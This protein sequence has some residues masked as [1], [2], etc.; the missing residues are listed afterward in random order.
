M[1]YLDDFFMS[2]R[3]K[4]GFNTSKPYSDMLIQVFS[5]YKPVVKENLFRMNQILIEYLFALEKSSLE[6][7]NFDLHIYYSIEISKIKD[8]PLLIKGEL[9]T[10]HILSRDF[11]YIFLTSKII[12]QLFMDLSEKL[13]LSDNPN[14]LKQ[15]IR[16]ER[17]YF[18]SIYNLLSNLIQKKSLDT[19][20][21]SV[22]ESAFEN[23]LSG[24][25]DIHGKIFLWEGITTLLKKINER[26]IE[27]NG[28]IGKVTTYMSSNKS[29]LKRGNTK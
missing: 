11:Q 24:F 8:L 25:E 26:N 7:P 13:S 29:K 22:Y 15:I 27:M 16:H 5:H 14:S 6:I 23:L 3:S 18:E 1:N 28:L 20:D 10:D 9:R 12:I 2:L 4:S 19:T 21:H 17:I